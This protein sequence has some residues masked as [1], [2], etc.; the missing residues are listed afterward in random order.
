MSWRREGSSGQLISR[1]TA[2]S[3][4]GS[5]AHQRVRIAIRFARVCRDRHQ[6]VRSARVCRCRR[7]TPPGRRLVHHGRHLR[8]SCPPPSSPSSAMA[9]ISSARRYGRWTAALVIIPA[10]IACFRIGRGP[11]PPWYLGRGPRPRWLQPPPLWFSSSPVAC[12]HHG[13]R[14]HCRM[15]ILRPSSSPTSAAAAALICGRLV[16]H[17]HRRLTIACVRCNH[18]L[19][20]RP[21]WPLSSHASTAAAV[22]VC[23]SHAAVVVIVA[24]VRVV[25]ASPLLSASAMM[26]RR[27]HH[28]SPT[29]CLPH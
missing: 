1:P 23:I 27:H 14:R 18:R 13:N 12:I 17:C 2:R 24:C 11:H 20:L 29:V 6:R 3:S 26:D 8:R 19:G 5:G 7:R 28:L 16:R 15:C 9:A 10:L 21:P 22:L 4:R 25:V